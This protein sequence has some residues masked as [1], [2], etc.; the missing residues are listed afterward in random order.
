MSLT[1]EFAPSTV[2]VVNEFPEDLYD[3]MRTFV[4]SHPNWDQYRLMQVALA[5]FLFQQG[6]RE[7]AVSRHYLDG[8]FDRGAASEGLSAAS[9]APGHCAGHGAM[10]CHRPAEMGPAA[11]VRA[12]GRPRV[13]ETRPEV[14]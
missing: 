14:A 5:G 13:A 11:G 9:P 1:P 4:R 7:R 6:S 2:T 8:L 3:A 12:M 10:P